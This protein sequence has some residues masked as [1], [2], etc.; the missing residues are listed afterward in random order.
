MFTTKCK[1]GE[2]I[3]FVIEMA[4]M[5]KFCPRCG[6]MIEVRGGKATVTELTPHPSQAGAKVIPQ[7]DHRVPATPGAHHAPPAAQPPAA[8][9]EQA[10]RFTGPTRP[11]T[12]TTPST[13]PPYSQKPP[14]Q[15]R[16]ATQH[17]HEQ[18]PAEEP[19][20][21]KPPQR[22]GIPINIVH[23]E[24]EHAEPRPEEPPV[25]HPRH[26]PHPEHTAG[27]KAPPSAAPHAKPAPP[28]APPQYPP[29]GP[30]YPQPPHPQPPA[31]KT[32]YDRY[33]FSQ[34]ENVSKPN[35]CLIAIIVTVVIFFFL[36]LLLSRST[37][38]HQSRQSPP[39]DIIVNVPTPSSDTDTHADRSAI[40]SA[41]T[42]RTQVDVKLDHYEISGRDLTIVFRVVN[43]SDFRITVLTFDF[44][45]LD[46]NNNTLMRSIVTA[47]SP[48][49]P[50]NDPSGA[51]RNLEK[52]KACTITKTYREWAWPWK[53]KYAL[54]IISVEASAP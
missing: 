38:S 27:T 41:D 47:V 30:A 36:F 28:P 43:N 2:E 7:E 18:P 45:I 34:V 35:G 53:N 32:P 39:K 40:P 13:V 20:H 48:A 4:V 21:D 54:K 23:A 19:G 33:T 52:G 15:P 17:E 26:A 25:V 42:L 5:T 22:H 9:A 12:L 10:P 1:C 49:I 8:P 24:K 50:P 29:K 14:E 11:E 51:T 3:P 31:A 16:P 44:R 37:S 6:A 46:A